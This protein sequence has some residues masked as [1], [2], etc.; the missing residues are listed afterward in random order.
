MKYSK[1]TIFS[2]NNRVIGYA[3]K[4]QS[5]YIMRFLNPTLKLYALAKPTKDFSTQY[6]YVTHLKYKNLLWITKY[7]LDIKE[8]SGPA[9][10]KIYGQYIM[11][12]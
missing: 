12:R 11:S 1:K 5:E 6:S 2:I 10:K 8:I 7:V 9:L 4:T 3:N